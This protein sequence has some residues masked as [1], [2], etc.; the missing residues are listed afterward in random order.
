MLRFLPALVGVIAVLVTGVVHGLWTDRWQTS[1]ACA[2]AAERMHEL[3]LELGEWTGEAVEFERGRGNPVAGTLYRRYTNRDGVMV[4]V[5]M[6]CGRPGP[7]AVHT[8]DVCYAANGYAVGSKEKFTVPKELA[9]AGGTFLTSELRKTRASEQT[10]L[11]AFWAW[12]AAGGWEAPEEPRLAF[13]GKP[14][15]VKLY[16]I[17]EM[18]SPGEPLAK[19]P[20][21]DLMRHLLP[22]LE[23]TLFEKL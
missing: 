7:I 20:C 13:A 23:K 1:N 5:F 4:Q 11:R 18:S 14:V 9:P 6:V 8:P 12:N 22:A 2:S 16:V 10:N 17:R 3:P 19:D 21:L 15:L